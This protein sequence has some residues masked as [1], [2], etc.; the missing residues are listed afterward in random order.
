M[1]FKGGKGR[2]KGRTCYVED[3]LVLGDGLNAGRS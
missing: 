2:S 1:G 3:D